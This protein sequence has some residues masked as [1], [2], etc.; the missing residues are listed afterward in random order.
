MIVIKTS[1]VAMREAVREEPVREIR[2]LPKD[3]CGLGTG[4]LQMGEAGG[5]ERVNVDTGVVIE[6]GNPGS[7]PTKRVLVKG[8]QKVQ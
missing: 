4:G 3:D 1:K 2:G 5:P 8:G 7:V 6:E